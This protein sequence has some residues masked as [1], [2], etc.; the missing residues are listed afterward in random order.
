MLTPAGVVQRA[1]P[2]SYDPD[3]LAITLSITMPDAWVNINVAA[4]L[5]TGTDPIRATCDIQA[6]VC[7]PQRI[8]IDCFAWGVVVP[9]REYLRFNF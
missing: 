5:V 4:S 2:C 8:N 6:T 1:W 3:P 9:A 7:V